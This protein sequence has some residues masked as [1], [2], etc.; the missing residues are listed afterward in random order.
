[1]NPEVPE[2]PEVPENPENPGEKKKIS[3]LN[4]SKEL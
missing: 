3:I 1:V 2:V 4:K